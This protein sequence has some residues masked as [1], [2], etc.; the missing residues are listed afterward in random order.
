MMILTAIKGLL[1]T[2]TESGIRGDSLLSTS[3]VKPQGGVG[4]MR[5][6]V[7][8]TGP[9]Q[10]AFVV[11]V[12]LVSHVPIQPAVDLDHEPRFRRLKTHWIRV[13]QDARRSGWIRKTIAL[14]VIVIYPI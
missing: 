8:W 2:R 7:L 1:V 9:D 4:Q 12:I 3:K 10:R 5:V 6:I 14:S 11:V 13:N